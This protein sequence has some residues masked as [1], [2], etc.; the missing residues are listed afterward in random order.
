MEIKSSVKMGKA[1][2]FFLII[3]V[4]TFTFSSIK[5]YYS[6]IFI[7]GMLLF[8]RL[9]ILQL[10]ANNEMILFRYSFN[11]FISDWKLNWEN[12]R[13]I[14][15]VKKDLFVEGRNASNCFLFE[16]INDQTGR[17]ISKRF[18]I[19][20]SD[21]ELEKFKQLCEEMQVIFKIRKTYIEG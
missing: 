13:E 6:L 20:L 7:I 17:V 11:F 2:Y 1:F 4:I 8:V 15:Y 12:V 19:N 14:V 21:D 3:I 5:W 18:S 16:Y 9:T 10:I